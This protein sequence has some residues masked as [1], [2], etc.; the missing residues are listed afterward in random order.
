M[1][2]VNESLLDGNKKNLSECI[3]ANQIRSEGPFVKKFENQMA[4]YVGRKHATTSSSGISAL[5]IAISALSLQEGDI[6]SFII[7]SCAQALTK[8]NIKLVLVDSEYNAFNMKIEDVESK[9]TPKNKSHYD[10]SYLRI[11]Y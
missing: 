5:D 7:I 1:V 6:P 4:H 3:D 2:M 10:C 9:I 8:L 11:N